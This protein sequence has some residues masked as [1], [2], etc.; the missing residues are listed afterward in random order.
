MKQTENRRYVR[1]REYDK[2]RWIIKRGS[3]L[4]TAGEQTKK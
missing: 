1:E 2:M 3:S 4:K